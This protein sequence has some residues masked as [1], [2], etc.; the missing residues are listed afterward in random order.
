MGTVFDYILGISEQSKKD[1]LERLLTYCKKTGNIELAK[2]VKEKGLPLEIF[3]SENGYNDVDGKVLILLFN[4]FAPTKIN[5]AL[6]K[7][8][9]LF[10]WIK[11]INHESPEFEIDDNGKSLLD[12]NWSYNL[13]K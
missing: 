9:I 4:Q 3:I 5:H 1:K 12:C 6:D 7:S 2:T 10:S 11:P 13:I 8:Q